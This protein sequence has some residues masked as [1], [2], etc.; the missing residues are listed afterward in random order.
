MS[1]AALALPLGA[2]AITQK[3]LASGE[4]DRLAQVYAVGAVML[5]L[6]AVHTFCNFFVDYQGHLMGARMERD[7]RQELFDHYQKL[8]LS[9]H[10]GQRTGQLMS[11][12]TNDLFWLAELF[13]HGPE[14]V[15]V[16]LLTFAGVFAISLTIH[17]EL[18]LLI[19]VFLPLMA[20]YAFYFNK[21]MNIALRRSKERIGDVN[22]Q[23]E[24]TLAGMRVV[25]SFAN[26][27][28]EAEKFARQNERFLASRRHGYRSEAFFSGGTVAFTQ[29]ITVA[30]VVFGAARIV[31][32]SLDLADLVTF[33]LYTG[34][35]LEPIRRWVNFARLYQEGITGF[36]R[37]VEMLAITPAI[38]DAPGAIEL[39]TAR[40]AI[41]FRDVSFRY[42]NGGGT[43]LKNLSLQIAAGDYV[44][45]VGFSG[46]GK[47]TLCSLI[48]RFYDVSAGDILLD[49]IDIRDIRLQ[50]L[51]RHIGVVH[52]DVYLFAGTVAGNIRYG[53]LD[54]TEEEIVAAARMANAHEFIVK[55]P[56]GY[57]TDIGQRGVRLSGGQKQR[58]S[59]AR[60]F[61]KDPPVLILDEATSSLD[62]DSEAAIRDALEQL[63]RRRTTI[64]IAHRLSTIQNARRILVLT[65]NGIAEEG[66]HAELLARNGAYAAL[67]QT[68]LSL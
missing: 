59:I 34:L 60:A 7:M 64:V 20:G 25:H 38:Q 6:V 33:L 56:Q 32:A 53:R 27:A 8:P 39:P 26:E 17:A 61:L 2:R 50:S 44:A 63:A 65:E 10:D 43:V 68:Q 47:T 35:L 66:T 49:G 55:L 28:L 5:A 62:N 22:A 16:G 12:L 21:R 37:F 4:P 9:F 24:D 31:Q 54:A 14:D 23:V 15:L 67:Y 46:I 30:V 18:A 41:D 29:L 45:L 52:Q 11:R 51:R 42:Q 36:D 57:N 19:F 13:H 40:G 1:L 58:L 48:P 3:I